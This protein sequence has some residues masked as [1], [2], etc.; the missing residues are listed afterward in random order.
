MDTIKS[1]TPT[2]IPFHDC[3]FKLW[4]M[5]DG[6]FRELWPRSFQ[7]HIGGNFVSKLIALEASDKNELTLPKILVSLEY[8][9]GPSSDRMFDSEKGSFAFPFLLEV[10]RGDCHF[11]YL[12]NVSDSKG[13]IS[14]DL[15][16]IIDDKKY[17]NMSTYSSQK[18]IESELSVEDIESLI[19]YVWYSMKR[20][21]KKLI[22]LPQGIQPF[23]RSINAVNGIYGFLNGE[24][25]E[26]CIENTEEYESTVYRLMEENPEVITDPVHKIDETKSWIADITG[27]DNSLGC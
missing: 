14:F 27:F 8:M 3:T 15:Y 13:S 18:P 26:D 4:R 2:C 11:Y 5:R 9:F 12:L 23:F 22:Q 21:V 25:F 24:F 19:Y 7:I 20:T 16:R 10:L 17:W 1:R 6:E